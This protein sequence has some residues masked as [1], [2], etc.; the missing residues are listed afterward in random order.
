MI[1]GL[2]IEIFEILNPTVY[3]QTKF[4]FSIVDSKT[5]SEIFPKNLKFWVPVNGNLTGTKMFLFYKDKEIGQCEICV[6]QDNCGKVQV[7]K[8]VENFTEKKASLNKTMQKIIQIRVYLR[9][10]HEDSSQGYLNYLKNYVGLLESKLNTQKRES[11]NLKNE[12]EK[13]VLSESVSERT[14]DQLEVQIC[15]KNKIIQSFLTE[16]NELRKNSHNINNEN[17]EL[18]KR[19]NESLAK[20]YE[21]KKKTPKN[22][23]ETLNESIENQGKILE[24]QEKNRELERNYSKVIQEFEEKSKDFGRI[25]EKVVSEKKG[26]LKKCEKLEKLARLQKVEIEDLMITISNEKAKNL[27]QDSV[28]AVLKSNELRIKSL[29]KQLTDEQ[30]LNKKLNFEI[31]EY[32]KEVS[33]HKE[34]EECRIIELQE[35]VDLNNN[36]LLKALNDYSV[37]KT[38][39]IKAEQAKSTEELK[40]SVPVETDLRSLYTQELEKLTEFNS[41]TKKTLEN[42][43]SELRKLRL[44]T[45]NQT[46]MLTEKDEELESLKEIVI[47]LQNTPNSNNSEINP[48]QSTHCSKQQHSKSPTLCISTQK[49]LNPKKHFTLNGADNQLE[50]IFEDINLNKKKLEKFKVLG[51]QGSNS[52]FFN[53]TKNFSPSSQLKENLRESKSLKSGFKLNQTSKF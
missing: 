53:K 43:D 16:F 44:L 42:L 15:E 28:G 8:F 38:Q 45:T 17:I 36:K 10:I 7:L 22:S 3:D 40:N 19:L 29:E 14:I 12:F 51:R 37:L 39:L 25:I 49:S 34:K 23:H 46:K 33:D 1:K 27:I 41:Q 48:F 21:F 47:V 11:E 52:K 13:R 35:T 20:I 18:K 6:D 24:L 26:F 32:K 2:E 4:R 9:L 30:E 5:Y 31:L 50:E